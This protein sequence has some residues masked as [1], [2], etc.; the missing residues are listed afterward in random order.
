MAAIELSREEVRA[1]IESRHIV[2]LNRTLRNR[3]ARK[4]VRTGLAGVKDVNG[5]DVTYGY[6]VDGN[7][8]SIETSV[9]NTYLLYKGT[10]C[11]HAATFTKS[12]NLIIACS[13]YKKVN[14]IDIPTAIQITD[15][16]YK[17]VIIHL[18]IEDEEIKH[19]NVC[20]YLNNKC[21]MII[22]DDE[23]SLINDD[24]SYHLHKTENNTITLQH[25]S[26]VYYTRCTENSELHFGEIIRKINED[27]FDKNAEKIFGADLLNLCQKVGVESCFEIVNLFFGRHVL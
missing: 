16:N 17:T 23:C 8:I 18:T 20:F 6:D 1:I 13:N 22:N 11:K 10:I 21:G 24:K 7:I 4:V 2:K 12:D 25:V 3:T 9:A 27:A 15:Q 19:Q 26:G 5:Q 14:G